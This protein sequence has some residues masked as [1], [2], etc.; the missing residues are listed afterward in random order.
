VAHISRWEDTGGWAILALS[1]LTDL[2]FVPV[3]LSL[4]LALKDLNRNAMLV[5]T[6][7]VELF[8]ALDLAVTWSNYASL[9]TLAGRYASATN[10][11]QRAAYA[12]A[13]DYRHGGQKAPGLQP[14]DA[15]SAP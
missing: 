1:V 11:A 3:G 5:A 8:V 6:A 12:A 15:W 14:G 9:I 2:L 7:F 4:Y 13:A 10:D